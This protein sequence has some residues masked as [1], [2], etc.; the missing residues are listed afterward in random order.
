MKRILM[1]VLSALL[2]ACSLPLSSAAA[3]KQ[4]FK[5]VPPAKHFAQAVNELAERTIIGGY[6]DGTFKPSRSITRGQAA[7]IIAKMIKLDMDSVKNPHFKDVSTANGYYKA[8]AAMAEKG[9]IGGY[10][11]GRYG[12]NDPIKRGQ[13]ASILVKAF[14]L[15]RDGDISNPFKDVA[16]NTSHAANIMI[17]YK[18]GITTGT[19]PSTFSPN[20]AI[21]RGQAAKMIK[22]TEDARPSNVVT[23]EPSDL[24]WEL[25]QS[26]T[27]N[28]MNSGLFK[29]V[30]IK[31][32][33]GYT[34]DKVQLIPLKEG[35]GAIVFHGRA[36]KTADLEHDKNYVHV[37]K[38]DGELKLTL[39][40]TEDVL[41][42]IARLS[43]FGGSGQGD[44]VPGDVRNV[45][46]SAMDG[47]L[48]ND[49]MAFKVCDN[50]FICIEIDNPGEYI[51][52]VRFADGKE[53]RYGIE[54]KAAGDK[55]YYTMRTLREQPT[56]SYGEN[57]KYTIGKYSISP[58]NY[59]QIADV[60]RE[61][62]TNMFHFTGKKAGKF[63][64]TY[65][66]PIH[67][68]RYCEGPNDTG[69]CFMPV[70][71]GIFIHV[72]QIGS[73]IN[74]WGSAAAEPDH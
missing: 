49:S 69:E 14:D 71:T 30:L 4:L 38:E 40:E 21:T 16:P 43:M 33:E 25:I 23:L 72:T 59:E 39:E 9:I 10:G 47:K 70:Y 37:K 17:I 11:D 35:I 48:M 64:I 66:H 31:G 3:D 19:T 41:P 1:T 45:S 34:K 18:L 51:A 24:G 28:E 20:A 7:A 60:T 5:D 56:F 13:M 50:Y 12:P 73:I 2:I 54:A 74:V 36:S 53:V 46:L 67:L 26:I 61:P 15:P 68:D 6:P 32:K 58:E 42:T 29:A 22:A 52:A 8:I 63:E 44:D 55:I 27:D 65:E 62:G 57:D